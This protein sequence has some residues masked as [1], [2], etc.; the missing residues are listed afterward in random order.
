MVQK[1][2]AFI[3]EYSFYI[4]AIALVASFPFSESLISISVGWIFLQ[5]FLTGNYKYKLNVLFSD[6]TLWALLAVFFVYLIGCLFCRD[7]ETGLYELRKTMFWIIIPIGVA[8]ARKINEK[9]FWTLLFIFVVFVTLSTFVAAV[10]IIFQEKFY[11]TDIRDASFVSHVSFSFQII[12]S[13]FILIYGVLIRPYLFRKIKPLLVIVWGV[14]LVVY[15]V[16]QKSLIGIISFYASGLIIVLWTIGLFE[17]KNKRKILRYIASLFLL[18][19]FIYLGYVAM[20]FQEVKDEMP[21]K[22]QMHTVNGNPY[23]F[24]FENKQRENGH[25]VH[26]FICKRE[27]E[28]AWHNKTNL[29]LNDK[30]AAGY[31]I[32]Y[33]LIRYLTSKGLK[34]DAQGVNELTEKDIENVLNGVSNHIFVDKKYSLY[35][36]I[37]QTFWE[38]EEYTNTG[39]PNNQ[40]LSQRIEYVK[41]AYHIIKHNIW[42]IGTGNYKI[43][44]AKAYNEINTKL[45]PEFRFHVHNQYLGYMVK[46]GF[47][48]MFIILA[49]LIFSIYNKHQFRNILMLALLVI[50][51]VSN[52]GEAIL[53]THVG[54]TFFLF[55]IS[56]FIWHSPDELSKSLNKRKTK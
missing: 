29:S 46:F 16:M 48:G 8:S 54:L 27:L 26:W 4:F 21:L 15:L 2:L 9:Q 13:L 18:L 22:E 43:E 19:P 39:N 37:Y 35:P 28:E 1:I 33:T 17:S 11:I 49:L 36:R 47:L 20:K 7:W 38:I 45:K 25:Y 53:E 44:F 42:G 51:F 6:R 10:K 24:K 14:W 32:Y 12:F 55:F 41:A 50:L 34:K 31:R 40:S 5:A 52:F 23:S 56:I 3:K 30:D